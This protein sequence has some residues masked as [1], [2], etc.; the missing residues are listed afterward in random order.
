M[1]EWKPAL[2]PWDAYEVSDQG[3]VRNA[4]TGHVLKPYKLNT[5]ARYW[6]VWLTT[7]PVIEVGRGKAVPVHLLVLGAFKGPRPEGLVGLHGPKGPDDN[8]SENL[9]WGTYE[10]NNGS[11]RERD[12]TTCRGES[13]GR[14]KLTGDIVLTIRQRY[15]TTN[16]S[17]YKLSVEYNVTETCIRN[18]IKRQSWQHI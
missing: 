1:I 17:M 5:D 8:T 2:Y 16:I 14:A 11:D 10:Q 7:G 9:C 15:A 12:N 6:V 18:V 4:S 3:T 13:H